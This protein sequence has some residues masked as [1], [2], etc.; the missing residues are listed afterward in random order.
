MT[1][2]LTGTA[3]KSYAPL[4]SNSL[5]KNKI[6]FSIK[7]VEVVVVV[8]DMHEL[9]RMSQAPP[10]RVGRS[11]TALLIRR[12]WTRRLPS[13]VFNWCLHPSFTLYRVSPKINLHKM[14]IFRKKHKTFSNNEIW[15]KSI[16]IKLKNFVYVWRIWSILYGYM[17]ERSTGTITYQWYI[18]L[19]DY[20]SWGLW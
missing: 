9:E 12:R 11:L 1:P 7:V 5:F 14:W 17:G 6:Y 2:A 8:S 15:K 19:I 13:L 4:D 10:R 20:R 3:W 16:E 18:I